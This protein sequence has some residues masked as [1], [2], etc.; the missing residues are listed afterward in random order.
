MKAILD[1]AKSSVASR[2]TRSGKHNVE[3]CKNL[4]DLAARIG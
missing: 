4:G 2:I 3:F 1:A